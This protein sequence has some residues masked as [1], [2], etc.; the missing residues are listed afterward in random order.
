MSILLTL[1]EMLRVLA[2]LPS[3]ERRRC[4]EGPRGLVEA[5]RREGAVRARRSV[6]A[7]R[8]LQRAIQLVDAACLKRNCFR[9]ALLEIAL[10]AGAAAE[11]VVLG[12]RKDGDALVGHAWLGSAATTDEFPVQI[13]L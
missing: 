1:R 6:E 2:V 13:P 8:R 5:L 4:R 10:D 12:F 7:R 3:V 9:R 11:P